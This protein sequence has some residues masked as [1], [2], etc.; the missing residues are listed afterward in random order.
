MRWSLKTQLEK[1][2]SYIYYVAIQSEGA[3]TFRHGTLLL[4]PTSSPL[5]L[6]LVPFGSRQMTLGAGRH[7]TITTKN[8]F[9]IRKQQSRLYQKSSR[10]C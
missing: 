7:S 4:N 8:K 3:Y 10:T 2:T 1:K 6:Y 9:T 5:N